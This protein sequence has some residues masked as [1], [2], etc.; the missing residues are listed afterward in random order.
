MQN[1]KVEGLEL[2]KEELSSLKLE[3]S[4]HNLYKNIESINDVKTFMETHVF[5]VW[6]FMSLLKGLQKLLTNVESPW[7]PMGNNSTRRFINEIV[8]DEYA[9]S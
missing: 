8:L 4:N 2:I 1:L 9:P 5:A 7:T 3:L 6:D